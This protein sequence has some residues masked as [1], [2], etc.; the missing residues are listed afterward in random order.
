MSQHAHSLIL[1]ATESGKSFLAKQLARGALAGGRRVV[2]LNPVGDSWPCSW[3][4][5]DAEEFYDY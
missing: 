3:Q 4:T 5:E 1:G 2:V